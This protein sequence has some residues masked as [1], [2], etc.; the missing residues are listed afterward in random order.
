M[1][2]ALSFL[3]VLGLGTA[4]YQ[5]NVIYGTGQYDG[6]YDANGHQTCYDNQTAFDEA[7]VVDRVTVGTSGPWS[8]LRYWRNETGS[9]RIYT[10][11][12]ETDEA[13]SQ[14]T[15]DMTSSIGLI[16]III[17][18]MAATTIAGI[19]F[20]GSG[21]TNAQQIFTVTVLLT[22]W[23][24]FSIIALGLVSQIP[25]GLGLGFYFFLTLLYSIG[26]VHSAG[27]GD[28]L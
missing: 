21:I 9:Y 25:L 24:V 14:I 2:V 23:G 17:A 3:S 15:F 6:Y 22:I 4:E 12:T 16:G 1:L 18:V 11:P 19:K 10:T 5:N 13:N 27:G 28:D 26:I 7:G 8:T 20:F